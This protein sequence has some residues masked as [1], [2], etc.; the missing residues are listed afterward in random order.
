MNY[1]IVIPLSWVP[2]L[3]PIPVR[4]DA[5]IL[6]MDWHQGFRVK[7]DIDTSC[8]QLQKFVMSHDKCMR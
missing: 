5:V 4:H 8:T 6:A 2:G 3:W 1:I 7:E